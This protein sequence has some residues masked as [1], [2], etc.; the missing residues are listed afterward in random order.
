M[1]LSTLA[2]ALKTYHQ[3]SCRPPLQQTC[4]VSATRFGE[5]IGMTMSNVDRRFPPFAFGLAISCLDLAFVIH[6]RLHRAPK[7]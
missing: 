5:H 3:P 2:H 1:H 7:A 4:L 6:Q